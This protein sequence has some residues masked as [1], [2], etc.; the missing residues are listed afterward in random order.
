MVTPLLTKSLLYK[1]CWVLHLYLGKYF[2]T[3]STNINSADS[4]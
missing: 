3:Y 1:R 2:Y 4:Q